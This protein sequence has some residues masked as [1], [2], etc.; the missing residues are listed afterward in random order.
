MKL[1]VVVSLRLSVDL[2][3]DECF[4]GNLTEWVND[5]E[6]PGCDFICEVVGDVFPPIWD[7][8][9]GP[10]PKGHLMVLQVLCKSHA[11]H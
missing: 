4:T 1:L 8:G 6:E 2:N 9:K 10:A 7:K 11:I 3:D 5:L